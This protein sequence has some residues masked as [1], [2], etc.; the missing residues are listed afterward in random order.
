MT[1]EK[2]RE[3]RRDQRGVG[4]FMTTTTLKRK[5]VL[6]LNLTTSI[7]LERRMSGSRR[8]NVAGRDATRQRRVDVSVRRE[9]L[10]VRNCVPPRGDLS[11]KGFWS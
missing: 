5:F 8:R 11:W 2:K 10:N 9:V 6:E 7:A 3:R 1:R 4:S